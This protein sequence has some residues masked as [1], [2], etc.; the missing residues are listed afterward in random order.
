VA[1]ENRT[2]KKTIATTCGSIWA[3]TP[4]MIAKMKV[5]MPLHWDFLN[6]EPQTSAQEQR[7]RPPMS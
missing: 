5:V 1:G 7:A 6:R 4:K 2:L 3:I